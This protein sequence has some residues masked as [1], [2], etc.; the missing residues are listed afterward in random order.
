MGTP[1]PDSQPTDSH[2]VEFYLD[3]VE[4][5]ATSMSRGQREDLRNDLREYVAARR[6][7][8]SGAGEILNR[9]GDPA[10]LADAARRDRQ[11][12]NLTGYVA[13]RAAG[14]VGAWSRPPVRTGPSTAA[15]ILAVAL[16]T[17]GL[18]IGLGLLFFGPDQVNVR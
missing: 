5:A 3:Q 17:I 15:F 7:A 13:D 9:L 18:C 8:G 1:T 10:E 2:L 12:F 16:L 11:R 14:S 6:A 4:L